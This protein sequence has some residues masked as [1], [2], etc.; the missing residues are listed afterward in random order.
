M[1][2]IID[3]RILWS[4]SSLVGDVSEDLESFSELDSSSL[5]SS[6]LL[7]ANSSAAGNTHTWM[8]SSV[9][10]GS[11]RARGLS[12]TPYSCTLN[13]MPVR[14]MNLRALASMW[15]MP[16]G[17]CMLILGRSSAASLESCAAACTSAVVSSMPK[18]PPCGCCRPPV[19]PVKK[20]F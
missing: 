12:K 6:P 14:N 4:F 20:T 1:S 17:P 19:L 9:Q 15:A 13:G 5:S 11:E 7:M 8:F 18:R 10:E 3:W 16:G 2:L